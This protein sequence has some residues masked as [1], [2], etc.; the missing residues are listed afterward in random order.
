MVRIS[1]CDSPFNGL[2]WVAVGA[3]LAPKRSFV[4]VQA[5]SLLDFLPVGILLTSET[6]S[7]VSANA[8]A[9]EVLDEGS[10]LTMRGN[11]LVAVSRVHA[12]LLN[13][14]MRILSDARRRA[15]VAFQ[16]KRSGR[17]PVSVT[18]ASTDAR[19][20]SSLSA[21]LA[22]LVSDPELPRMCSARLFSEAFQMTQAESLV[23]CELVEGLQPT[24]IAGKL[25]LSIF[26]VR[27]HLKSMYRKTSTK[28]HCELLHLLLS[29]PASFRFYRPNQG[30]EQSPK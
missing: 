20:G 25:Q 30:L 11:H 29:A 19:R 22:I 3:L 8:A 13:D 17:R 27:N 10:V 23:A 12:K 14:A 24:G 2:L 18:V 26:T 28:S 7:V 6:G 9:R 1:Y 5:D 4:L 21:Q 16:A 15:P